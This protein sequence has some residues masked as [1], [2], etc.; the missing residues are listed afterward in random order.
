MLPAGLNFAGQNPIIRHSIPV[1]DERRFCFNF[2]QLKFNLIA[3]ASDAID[4]NSSDA[5]DFL[6]VRPVVRERRTLRRIR[7][8]GFNHEDHAER[9]T[10]SLD[11][12]SP[13]VLDLELNR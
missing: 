13:I 10:V 7:S 8:I 1:S 12:S 4:L 3:T 11:E 2:Q 9:L 6:V 5:L